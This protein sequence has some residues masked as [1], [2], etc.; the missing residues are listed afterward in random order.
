MGKHFIGAPKSEIIFV[1]S[2]LPF[3]L[4]SLCFLKKL[5]LLIFFTAFLVSVHCL[6]FWLLYLYLLLFKSLQ[7]FLSLEGQSKTVEKVWERN[8]E[9][10]PWSNPLTNTKMKQRDQERQLLLSQ[11][12]KS[13]K[14]MGSNIGITKKSSSP[15]IILHFGWTNNSFWAVQTLFMIHWKK[16]L[17]LR[18]YIYYII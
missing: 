16:M 8:T 13:D 12:L 18:K 14:F 2:N 1:Q 9:R 17:F 5:L 4:F 15:K 10:K 6:F 3:S 7:T 11:S